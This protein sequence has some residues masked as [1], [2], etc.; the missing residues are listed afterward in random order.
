VASRRAGR[1]V[2]SFFGISI[3]LIVSE[4]LCR[5]LDGDAIWAIHLTSLRAP[6]H[7]LLTSEP[8]TL[9]RNYASGVARATGVQFDWYDQDPEPISPKSMPLWT[10][11]RLARHADDSQLAFREFNRAFL[12]DRLCTQQDAG[13]FGQLDDFL[14][15][16]P[17]ESG[18]YPSYRLLREITTPGGLT[19]NAFGWR[20]PEIA[21]NKPPR[22]IR[23]AFVGASTTINDEGFPFS[24]P[25]LI[26]HWLNLW[27]TAQRG[28]APRFEIVNAARSGIN[29]HSIAA[30]V[31]EE[32]LPIDPDFVI[33]Y[34]GSNQ[35]LP[36]DYLG[37]RLGRL[38]PRPVVPAGPPRPVVARSA[39]A[40]R[41]KRLLDAWRG[42]DG[43]E[44]VKPIQWLRLSEL[45]EQHPDPDDARLP[46]ELPAIVRDLD[47]VRHALEPTRAELVLS[48]FLW[49][50]Q[51]GLRLD[52]PRQV[53][54]FTYLN[55]YWP[56]SYRNIRRLA[57]LQNRV[58]AG[59]AR[60]RGV[61]FIDLA[62]QFPMDANL[63]GDAIHLRYPGVRLHA[64]I[65]LQDLIRLLEPRLRLGALP[66]ASS[67]SRSV[68][69]AFGQVAPRTVTR[70]E[71]LSRCGQQ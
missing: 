30:I 65:V 12:Q 34:E 6:T 26:G 19:T 2:V 51:D 63:F 49:M 22:T 15:F 36:Q 11:A 55:G 8:S 10:Q 25:E 4:G 31:R 24:Y 38:Y 3:A 61:P 56:A 68:H 46:V 18:I 40:L 27:S 71:V 60:R 70:S 59:Y 54:L 35:F 21:L 39:L 41:A 67:A 42:G 50:V 62:G 48:S 52:L 64:W 16:D 23:L 7:A 66:R 17:L 69:P 29:S 13:Q 43:R 47:A 37:Y 57:D 32:V 44:P 5:W 20:G 14:Y 1:F 9:A 53:G 28:L 45:D 33:Y 58:F